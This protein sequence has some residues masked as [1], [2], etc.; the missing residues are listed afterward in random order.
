MAV[1]DLL[2]S[3]AQNEPL[4]RVAGETMPM[5]ELAV[6]H[7]GRVGERRRYRLRSHGTL[8]P[9][10]RAQVNTTPLA[11]R[12]EPRPGPVTDADDERLAELRR[13][14][15]EPV[16]TSVLGSTELEALSVHWGVDGREGDVW[17]RIDVPDERHEEVLLSPWWILGPE[18]GHPP[19]SET[20]IAAHLG[21]RLEDWVCETAFAWGQRRRA[22]YE[23]P[24]D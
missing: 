22:R 15:V 18:D 16:A 11:S 19:A 3:D 7:P 10:W 6:G 23:L 1:L 14:V 21:D 5:A 4:R 8:R 12:R 13:R 9:W 24:E 20:E 17:V 2:R